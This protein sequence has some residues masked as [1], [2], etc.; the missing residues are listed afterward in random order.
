MTGRKIVR[1]F[2]FMVLGTVSSFSLILGMAGAAEKDYPNKVITLINPYAPGGGLDISFQAIVDI[3]PEYLGQ[4]MIVSHKP[5]AGGAI[6]TASAAKAKPDGYTLYMGGVSPVVLIPATRKVSYSYDDFVPMGTF[7]KLFFVVCVRPESPWKTLRDLI[8]DAKQNP[9]KLKFSSYGVMS[10][11]HVCMEILN[12][13]AGIK[14]VN[15]PYTN[16][17]LALTAAIGGHVQISCN[18]IQA[19]LPHL[20]SGTLRALAISDTGRYKHLP[21]VPT[22]KELGFNIET[23]SWHGLM[24]PKGTPKAIVDRIWSAQ[25]KAFEDNKVQPRLEKI[26][27]IPFLYPPEDMDKI[28]R[29]DIVLYNQVVK[30]LGLEVK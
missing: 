24:A 28:I 14:T 15:I 9:G 16:D 22:F 17:S 26:G 19:A 29:A 8:N 4:K 23:F 1:L 7:D 27:L 30:D 5:G 10:A 6:G 11:T 12:H 25:K 20:L 18:T 13:E 3:L 2:L 21:D